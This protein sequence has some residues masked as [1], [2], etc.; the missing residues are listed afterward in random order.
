MS[1]ICVQTI[2][3]YLH[4]NR[5]KTNPIDKAAVESALPN[6][7]EENKEKLRRLIID[8]YNSFA[9]KT[10]ELGHT[11]LVKHV[12]D[13]QGQ[14]P[15][16]QRAYRTSPKQKE[17]A[18]K[19][20]KELMQNKIIHSFHLPRID[21]VLDLLQGQRYFSTLD[22][23]SGYWQIEL[24][25]ESKE[26]T[27]FIVDDNLYEWN[28]LAIGL[29]NA[30]G[31]FQRL[32]NSVLRSVTGK[33]CLVYLDDIIVFSKTIEEHFSNLKTVFSLLEKAHLKM[34][35]SKCKFLAQSVSYLGHN[36]STI[37]HPLLSQSK[38]KPTD[39]VT[40]N[41]E[42]IA[43]FEYLRLC[44][45]SEPILIYPDFSKEFLIYTDAS[46][47]GLG[48]PIAYASRHLNKGEIK[49]STIE[50]E[51]AAV[52]FGIKRFRH[53]L[54]DQ[55]FIIVS[56]HRPLQW[57][58]TFKDETGRLGRWAILLSNMKFSVQYRPGRVHENADFL[59]RIPMNLISVT[60]EDNNVMCQE[61]QKDS[62]C[63]AIVTFLEQ[64]ESW[65]KEDG[66]IPSWV[67]EIDYFFVED[68]LLCKHYEPTSAQRRNFEQCQVVV[69]LS[70]RKQLLQEYHDS[71]L[72]GH[73][74]TRR[75]FLRLRDKYYWPT[76]LRDVKEYC[77]SC[78][79]CA[80]G[81]RVHRA[82]AYLNPLDLATRPFEVL[83]L[84][85]LGPIKPYSLQ[86]NN[87]ILVITDYFSKWIEVIPLTNCTA[88]STCK[89][90]VERII[91]HHGPPTAIVTDRGSNFTSELFPH[92]VKL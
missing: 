63:K 13:T 64:N 76:M 90:L 16:R 3:I 55:P 61:Q 15:I 74:A 54:Q 89:A 67:S 50:K 28:R 66:P 6:I 58:Q 80:L 9:F 92:F 45:I 53:Y 52:V 44:L 35:L 57:L 30:P 33:I 73:M 17:V 69:P 65:K 4:A 12:I 40:L 27:A 82:K 88:L 85:F 60:P 62:L 14:G 72:S 2:S 91:L 75:T 81:R 68:G 43:A 49:Y 77:T 56:D 51:A 11:T 36:F 24:E 21:D 70:L 31:T 7:D 34:K 5:F 32:M 47:Y 71:P 46:N 29:T 22:L 8:N 39:S 1:L 20:I 37:A 84:D 19:I 38:G 86:G 18:Q 79:P 23:A 42:E 48:A 10:S 41:T 26:K 78:E 83:G 87:Y 59:S 25:E